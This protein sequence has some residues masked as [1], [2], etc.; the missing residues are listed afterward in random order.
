MNPN[1]LMVANRIDE[2]MGGSQ[3]IARARKE[4]ANPMT[5]G[6]ANG[7]V[8]NYATMGS[9]QTPGNSTSNTQPPV[10]Q[11]AAVTAATNAIAASIAAAVTKAMSASVPAAAPAKLPLPAPTGPGRIITPK[12]SPPDP[13]PPDKGGLS[14]EKLMGTLFA[15]QGGLSLLSGAFKDAS[16]QIGKTISIITD[17]SANI[18]TAAFAISG[19][20]SIASSSNKLKSAFGKLGIAGA[21]LA[22]GFEVFSGI[23][24][25]YYEFSG[26]N[27]R[28]AKAANALAEAAKYAAAQLEDY[29]PAQQTAIKKQAE[30]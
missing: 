2:P 6:A 20:S 15:V 29:D 26:A 10:N 25:L 21:A 24:E 27:E 13:E 12:V 28:A 1:G 4:G 11:S 19:F 23:K 14:G 3:G 5:Y 17:M 16:S 8:P 18:S 22:I 9:F 30:E 7:F